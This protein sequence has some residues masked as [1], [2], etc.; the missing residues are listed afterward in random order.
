M[1][2]VNILSISGHQ[3]LKNDKS[4]RYLHQLLFKSIVFWTSYVRSIYVL[5]LRGRL[6]DVALVIVQLLMFKVYGN[7]GASKIEFFNFSRTERVKGSK[8]A[9]KDK[10]LFLIDNW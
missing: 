5:C 3:Y 8:K 2:P 10:I 6:T 1:W 4:K 7:F 9:S